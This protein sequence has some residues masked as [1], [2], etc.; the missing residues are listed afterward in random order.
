MGPED[1]L[2][3]SLP[4]EVAGRCVNRIGLFKTL[5]ERVAS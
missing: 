2:D 5:Q 4:E 3:S 1:R